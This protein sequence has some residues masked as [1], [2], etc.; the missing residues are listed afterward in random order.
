MPEARTVLVVED[1]PEVRAVLIRLLSEEG[2]RVLEAND[3]VEA[4][5]VVTGEHRIDLVLSDISMPR[6]DGL[7]L[8]EHLPPTTRLL[9]MTGQGKDHWNEPP[10]APLIHK[11]F[12]PADLCAEV[13]RILDSPT[14]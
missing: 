6:M 12:E 8:A 1:Q 11:P 14:G 13:R 7:E 9:F 10:P 5:E 4:M 2:Y 3:G